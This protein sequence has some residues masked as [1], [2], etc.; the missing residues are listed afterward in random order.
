MKMKGLK[1]KKIGCLLDIFAIGTLRRKIFVNYHQMDVSTNQVREIQN[2][3]LNK[4]HVM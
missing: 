3:D 1:I 4:C 2:D